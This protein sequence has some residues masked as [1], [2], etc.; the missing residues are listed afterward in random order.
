M[1]RESG[2]LSDFIHSIP[3]GISLKNRFV[4]IYDGA[5]YFCVYTAQFLRKVDYL[6]QYSF[7]KLQ[8]YIKTGGAKIP[9]SILQESIHVIDME[10]GKVW[11][12]TEAISK[13]LFRSPPTFPLLILLMFLRLIH[14]AEPA[15]KWVAQSRYAI[16]SVLRR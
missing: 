15:Y 2:E 1:D 6:R 5:C 16:S 7:L 11:K 13:L 10:S 4:V 12:S 9:Y 3:A 14:V 8:D